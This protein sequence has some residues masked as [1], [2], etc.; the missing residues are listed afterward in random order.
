MEGYKSKRRGDTSSINSDHS[1]E[2]TIKSQILN[3]FLP[4][5]SEKEKRT[6]GFN[7]YPVV[8]VDVSGALP[9]IIGFLS[10]KSE[11]EDK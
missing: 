7:A 4:G 10:P 1:E 11:G 6:T 8:V 2:K 5:R 9:P 3:I